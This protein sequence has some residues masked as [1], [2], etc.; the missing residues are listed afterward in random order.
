[1]PTS[2]LFGVLKLKFSWA[3]IYMGNAGTFKS[4]KV[5][6]PTFGVICTTRETSV[7]SDYWLSAKA[8][9]TGRLS[10]FYVNTWSI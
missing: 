8:L 10:E 5:P 2:A 1:M 7:I 4:W 9:V 6:N 3:S